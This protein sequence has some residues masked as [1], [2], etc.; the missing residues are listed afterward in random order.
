L[1]GTDRHLYQVASA[2]SFCKCTCKGNSTIIALNPKTSSSTSSSNL[3]LRD[4][5]PH[6]DE[7]IERREEGEHSKEKP[8]HRTLTCNDCNRK[9]C[10]D[11]KL[12]ACKGVKDD[13]VFTTCFRMSGGL[14]SSLPVSR[15]LL[16]A[17]TRLYPITPGRLLTSRYA[18][19]ARL[20]QRRTCSFHF[21]ICDGRSIDLGCHQTSCA[22]MA[23]CMSSSWRPSFDFPTHAD[24]RFRRPRKGGHTSHFLAPDLRR[25]RV[26]DL[27]L[28]ETAID[29]S[30][31]QSSID[32][33]EAHL[34]SSQAQIF[35]TSSLPPAMRRRSEA[36]CVSRTPYSRAV[37]PCIRSKL[38]RKCYIH[39]RQDFSS[40]SML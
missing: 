25:M 36:N 18:I 11:Y 15:I 28:E 2:T 32:A 1:V 19:R 8:H 10:L 39:L 30:D 5:Q 14:C 33:L 23:C 13:E 26:E 6:L 12:P 35:P 3:S 34:G 20:P 22:E 4:L 27:R 29:S 38:F 9:F 40:Q 7:A 17:F 21:H 24:A 31:F 16:L 37:T